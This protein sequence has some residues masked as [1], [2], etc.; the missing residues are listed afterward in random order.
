MDQM[1]REANAVRRLPTATTAE[2]MLAGWVL[3]LLGAIESMEGAKA[4]APKVAVDGATV[5]RAAE[6]LEREQAGERARRFLESAPPCCQDLTC[7][8]EDSIREDGHHVHCPWSG[9]AT[10]APAPVMGFRR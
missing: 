8:G 9:E 5:Q 3:D 2:R 4:E 6:R 1:L 10:A 7:T